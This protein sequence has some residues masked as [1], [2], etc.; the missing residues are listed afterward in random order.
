MRIPVAGGNVVCSRLIRRL[1]DALEDPSHR[2]EKKNMK[3]RTLLVCATLAILPSLSEA[4][5]CTRAD[6]KGTWRLFGAFGGAIRC[7][8]IMPATGRT[9]A[10]S[11][12]C[13]IP[14]V[15]TDA[16]LTGT[17]IIYN[18]CRVSGTLTVSGFTRQI[19]GWISASKDGMS[20]IGY[21]TTTDSG[22]GAF[23]AVKN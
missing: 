22:D 5:T 3:G 15:V 4:G 19:D 18:T 11:S 10:S 17:V 21:E 14:H 12:T 6:L 1:F 20:G 2:K 23:S 13:T 8:L 9:I 16:P 7:N